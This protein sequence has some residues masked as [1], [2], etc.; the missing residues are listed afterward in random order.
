MTTTHGG[1][2]YYVIK[3]PKD[4]TDCNESTDSGWDNPFRPDG[5]LSRE[6]DE[7][8]ELIKG[9]KPI[10]PTPGQ[11]APPLP[12]CEGKTEHDSS[13]TSPLLKSTNCHGNSRPGQENGSAHGGTPAKGGNQPVNEKVG[14]SRTAT[15]EVARMTAQGPGDAS[16][17]EHVTLKK[18]PKCKC[19]VL[20]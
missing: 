7:I 18:K 14:S 2:M 15:V 9:G 11:N 10:T 12:G 8:V 17:V 13:S 3:V 16:Q 6:A 4:T 20:Q 5:D 19:C 1:H